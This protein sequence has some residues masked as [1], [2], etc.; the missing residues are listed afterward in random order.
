MNKAGLIVLLTLTTVIVAPIAVVLTPF[1]TL[2]LS[3]LLY[4]LFLYA[5]VTGGF[6]EV[7]GG[8]GSIK[9]KNIEELNELSPPQSV[10]PFIQK[11]MDQKKHS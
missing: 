5:I 10:P 4:G 2:F 7:P 3:L 9:S 6:P 8:A 11:I 1:V